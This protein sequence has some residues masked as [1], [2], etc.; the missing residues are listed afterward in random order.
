MKYKALYVGNDTTLI[1]KFQKGN[2]L[3][4]LK[5]IEQPNDINHYL[6]D[7]DMIIYEE[8]NNHNSMFFINLIKY[9]LTSAK[10]VVFVI[11]KQIDPLEYIRKGVHDVFD[12]TVGIETIQKRFLFV[13]EHFDELSIQKTDI[14]VTFKLPLWKRLFDITVSGIILLFLLPIFLIIVLAIR[15]ESKG[16][17]YYTSPRVGTGYQIFGFIKFRSMYTNA[18]KR[19]DELMKKNQYSKQ[20]DVKQVIEKPKEMVEDGAMLIFDEGLIPEGEVRKRKS[21]KRENTFFKVANDPRITKVGRILRNTSIDELPQLINVLKGDMSLVGNRPLPLYEAELLTT[22]QW[23]KRFLAPSGMT[24]LWQVTKRGGANQ[25][26]ADDRKQLD[27]EY[28]ENF[29]FFYDIKILLKTIP[30][31]LQHEN[32]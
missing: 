21:E 25:M 29:S 12:N 11:K 18:D 7:I 10:I 23:S 13:R 8:D 2:T 19:V 16:K 14:L 4:D 6:S 3:F 26:S 9:S 28:A 31:M 5:I 17:V 30:A 15:L 32:V 27:I 20:Q 22:D 24:G 1:Q